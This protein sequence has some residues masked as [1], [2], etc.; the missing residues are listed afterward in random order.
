M[1]AELG[2]AY[3]QIVPSAEG[4]S[5]SISSIISPEATS[6]GKTAGLNIAGGI[7]SALK[8]ATGVIAAGTA[9]VTTTLV[10]GS[11]EVASY[12]DNIDKMSQKMGLSAQAYQEWDAVMQHSGTSM[13]SMKA[14]MKTLANAA[15]T[16]SA[17]FT[18]LGI[19]QEQLN[20]MS[21]EQ[22]FEATISALQNVEDTTTRTYLAGKTLGKGA[23][24]LGALLNTSAE[25][26]QAMRDRVRELGGVMS[27]EAVKSAALF[28][29]NMQDLQTAISGVGRNMM[30]QLLPSMNEIIAG[31]TSLIIGEEDATQ[32]LSSGF[33]SLFANLS[34]IAENIVS[35]ITQMMPN[36]IN[37]IAEILPQLITMA[38]QLIISISQALV[39]AMPQLIT[40]VVPALAVAAVQIV[41]AFGQAL[42]EAAPQLISA[43]AEMI[44]V[45]KS[46]FGDDDL[47]DEGMQ[48]VKG[49]L[50]GITAALPD[51]LDKGVEILSN[52][53]NGIL[54]N[55]PELIAAAGEIIATFTQFLMQNFPL[56]VQK[57]AEL[58]LN[59][60]N[61]IINN[62]PQI[63]TAV[64]Q[65]I[66]KLL[67]TIVQNLPRILEAGVQIIAKLAVGLI[68]AIPKI[69]AAIPQ[70]IAS[71]VNTF[72]QF[73]WGEIGRNILEGVKN[74]IIGAISAVVDAARE[75]ASAIWDAVSDF[76]D[77]G[78]PS[79]KMAWIGE[80]VD[81]GFAKGISENSDMI[82][83]A[84]SDITPDMTS[85]LQVSADYKKFGTDSKTSSP[86]TINM[87]INGAEGQSVEE[88]AEL[89]Q[90]RINA[91]VKSRS[92]V[93]A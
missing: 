42:I 16:N 4:I 71:I 55:L 5:G 72:A 22:L 89:I 6:A 46:S 14:S 87:T 62:L 43:G 50:D 27:D 21:Q 91:A 47:L 35:T 60:A 83:E 77:I 34:G 32:K 26:T 52:V 20:N 7:G 36:I 2:K 40:T 25:D 18:E 54:N 61:G 53:A 93:Y 73:D 37:G 68:Q 12:G 28:Q 65:V 84:I 13:A 59:L 51:V 41:V 64:L 3:V 90:E 45:L 92:A 33:S 30:S 85:Q 75:A 10:K 81:A 79:K 19:T 38:T 56:I 69:I 9:A 15:Q 1:G 24:E 39:D 57:G 86:L 70:I 63:V 48:T 74:G 82:D 49:M 31:F 8:T 11:Q 78:S 17:A 88:L 29:D 66:A 67:A 76:F 80:M 58:L 23:T 44:E